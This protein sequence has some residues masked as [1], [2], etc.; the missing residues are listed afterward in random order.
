MPLITP[1]S[2]KSLCIF[3]PNYAKFQVLILCNLTEED[4]FFRKIVYC[5]QMFKKSPGKWGA[6]ASDGPTAPAVAPTCTRSTGTW[7][8]QVMS[9]NA[10]RSQLSST[11]SRSWRWRRSQ[12][13]GAICQWSRSF[14]APRSS[15]CCPSWVLHHQHQPCF[16]I[17]KP[18]TFFQ[19][20]GP[21]HPQVCQNKFLAGRKPPRSSVNPNHNYENWRRLRHII[22]KLLKMSN[23][24]E[25]VRSSQRRGEKRHLMYKGWEK[26]FSLEA[27]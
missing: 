2:N 26:D 3:A 8:P 17:K 11:Q 10:I 22:S 21:P 12:P 6:W 18:N 1:L 24:K 25:N 23:K 27:V 13:R 14:T 19:I 7:L 4:E 5:R 15:F 20:Q 9:L 16:T